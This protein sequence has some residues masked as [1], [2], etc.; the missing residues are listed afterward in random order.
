MR[1]AAKEGSTGPLVSEELSTCVEVEEKT[2][3]LQPPT[4]NFPWHQ[5]VIATAR[6]EEGSNNLP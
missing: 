2:Q 6:N 1:F 5:P 3:G 4:L